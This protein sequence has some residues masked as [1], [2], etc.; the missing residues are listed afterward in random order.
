VVL[1]FLDK[2]IRAVAVL[3]VVVVVEVAPVV[4]EVSE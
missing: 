3:M 1:V 4:V 2:V